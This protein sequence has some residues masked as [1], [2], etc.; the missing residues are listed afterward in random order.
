MTACLYM[1]SLWLAP[2]LLLSH[3]VQLTPFSCVPDPWFPRAR[4]QIAASPFRLPLP[5]S[6]KI[7]QGLVQHSPSL[8]KLSSAVGKPFSNTSDFPSKTEE[9]INTHRRLQMASRGPRDTPAACRLGAFVDPPPPRSI[10][11]L[12][13]PHFRQ[14]CGGTRNVHSARHWW[15][16]EVI[17]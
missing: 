11:R 5:Q 8:R 14:L 9:L 4:E 16:A 3:I 13:M 17:I 15:R 7:F 1:R 12:P 2:S 6:P 10:A